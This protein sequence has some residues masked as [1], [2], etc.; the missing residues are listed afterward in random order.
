MEDSRF[1]LHDEPGALRLEVRGRLDE[2]LL[3]QMLAGLATARSMQN[4]R[5]LVFDLRQAAAVEPEASRRLFSVA[6]P[7]ARFLARD[8]HLPGMTD[9]QAR[10][11]RLVAESR[12][13][14]MRRAWCLLLRLLRPGCACSTCQPERLWIL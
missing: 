12:F 4:G 14:A 7:E 3:A 2:A 1:Y 10:Q 13:S 8:E 9:G 5:P 6:G 11:A